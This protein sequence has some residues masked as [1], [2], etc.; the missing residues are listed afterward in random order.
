M[1][2]KA[3]TPGPFWWSLAFFLPPGEPRSVLESAWWIAAEGWTKMCVCVCVTSSVIVEAATQDPWVTKGLY[4]QI[5]TCP[6]RCF[7]LRNQNWLAGGWKGSV[8]CTTC[9]LIY[10]ESM[11]YGSFRICSFKI[12]RVFH[13]QKWH[14]PP[15]FLERNSPEPSGNHWNCWSHKTYVCVCLLWV[16]FAIPRSCLCWGSQ[17]GGKMFGTK[18][19]VG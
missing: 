8:T 19:K 15:G 5:G 11:I 6:N 4:P 9:N 14:S 3:Y 7:F 16:Q 13:R 2:M 17:K 18:E 10:E 12:G 1:H